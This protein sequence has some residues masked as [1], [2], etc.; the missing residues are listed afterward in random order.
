MEQ[1]RADFPYNNLP[2]LPPSREIETKAILR[3]CIKSRSALAE[4]KQA[5]ELIP[6]QSM[7]INT[8]PIME[9]QAS[10]EIENIVTTSDKLF[11]HLQV[12]DEKVDPA[13]K[14][15]M[16]YRS[17][18]FKGVKLLEQRPLCTQIAVQ[19][20]STIKSRA[21]DIRCTTGTA[22]RDAIRDKVIYTPPVG[23]G[24]IRDKLRN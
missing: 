9:A 19:V 24:L 14:E 12:G 4:L 3:Q 20:C 15:A 5:V 23:E 2:L 18:L 10:S 22:L 17:A 13:T 21:M 7:L 1:W 16:N 8:L 11:Q 6:N